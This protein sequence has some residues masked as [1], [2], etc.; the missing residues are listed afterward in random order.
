MSLN[1]GIDTTSNKR[2]Y[3]W[4]TNSKMNKLYSKV[5]DNLHSHK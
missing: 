5:R 3:S 1:I 4:T 2:F